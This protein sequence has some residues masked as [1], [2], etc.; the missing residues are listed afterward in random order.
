MT[1]HNNN[2]SYRDRKETR[3]TG[4]NQGTK[5]DEKKDDTKQSEK[6]NAP[7]SK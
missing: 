1:N 7:H 5:S 2:T 4:N 3:M 6:T